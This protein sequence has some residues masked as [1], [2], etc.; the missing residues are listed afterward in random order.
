MN[1]SEYKKLLKLASL[2]N[3][4]ESDIKDLESKYDFTL[5]QIQLSLMGTT[6]TT[7]YLTA[8]M[9]YESAIRSIE[10]IDAGLERVLLENGLFAKDYVYRRGVLGW[11]VD[12]IADYYNIS[13]SSLMRNINEWF[14]GD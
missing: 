8:K 4:F 3:I 10:A 9:R 13:K 2:R 12:R 5:D 14:G 6:D 7:K 1:K 11:K